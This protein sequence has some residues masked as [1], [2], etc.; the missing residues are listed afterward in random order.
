MK[1]VRFKSWVC[2]IEKVAY[3]NGRTALLLRDIEDG[4]PVAKA[5]VNVPDASLQDGQVIIKNY[6]E[7]EGML[8]ALIEAKIVSHPIGSIMTGYEEC[9]IC[10]L[11]I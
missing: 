5:T 11:L 10:W 9:P 2:N 4:A 1:T 3:G 6:D 7:N 8:N